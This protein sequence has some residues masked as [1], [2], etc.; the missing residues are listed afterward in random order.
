MTDTKAVKKAHLPEREISDYLDR[1][2][3]ADSRK[4]VELHAAECT[5]CL[6]AIVS[7]YESVRLFKKRKDDIMKKLNIY[8]ILAIVSFLLSFVVPQYFA[9]FLVA[10]ALLGIKW[11][12][13][14]KS[15][16][17]LVMIYDAWKRGDEKAASRILSTLEPGKKSRF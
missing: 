15:T 3:D 5:D 11:I 10:A 6:A 12:S 16:K 7:A 13:D 8:L 4:E 17:M 2:L 9:Q 14:S 1:R